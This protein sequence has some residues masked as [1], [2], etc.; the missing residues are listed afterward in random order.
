MGRVFVA[1]SGGVDSSVAAALAVR[2]GHDVVGVT[3]G[4]L[5]SDVPGDADGAAAQMTAA[6][7]AV[8]DLLGIEHRFLDLREAFA[9]EVT[10][11][12]VEEYAHGRTPN[13]CVVCNER[14]KFGA[15]LSW[16][17]EEGGEMLASGHY[18]RVESEL[19]GSVWLARS[20]DAHKDQS[21]FLYRLG[22]SALERIMFPI[23]ELTKSQVRSMATEMGLPTAE[24]DESQEACFL[25]GG[26]HVGFVEARTG[27]P[28]GGEIVDEHGTVLA[29]HEGI[30]RFTVGQRRGLGIASREPLYVIRIDAEN[31]RVVVGPARALATTEV[32]ADDAVWRLPDATARV[33]AR[34]RYRMTPVSAEAH[35]ERGVLTVRFDE[36]VLGAAPGQSVVCYVG[37]R[38]VGG[39]VLA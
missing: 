16:V 15:L 22:R 31:D 14:I 28:R 11:P 35:F 25:G 4:L 32:V 17:L 18:A 24:H 1:M 23:G 21:Y 6:A 7:R 27:P 36:P 10:R 19:D 34:T 30:A 29:R 12:F 33:D 2:G 13:P 39:G 8:C 5:P 9:A 26:G 20:A 38:V 37:D 3:M